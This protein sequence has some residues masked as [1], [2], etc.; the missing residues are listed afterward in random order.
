[1]D[2]TVILKQ[3]AEN[4]FDPQCEESNKVHDS[5]GNYIMC[6]KK[7]SELPK[8]KIQPALKEFNGLKVIYT[9]IA[10]KSLRKRDYRQHFRGNNA[11][12]STLR[13]SLGVLLGYP[14]IPRDKDPLTGK[15]KFAEADEAKLTEWMCKNLVMYFLPSSSYLE[16]E[17]ELIRHF[18]PPLNLKNSLYGKNTSFREMLS[19]LRRNRY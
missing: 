2:F 5:P 7:D 18:D 13:K 9:G 12:G 11:G 10:S 8:L 19:L 15:T 6:L 3:F 4:V 16:T 1:M 17:M 14:L